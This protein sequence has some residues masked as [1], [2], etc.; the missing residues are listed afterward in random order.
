MARKATVV[1]FV[2]V[3]LIGNIS[4]PR[5]DDARP[6]DPKTRPDLS[7]AKSAAL[8]WIKACS[9]GDASLAHQILVDDQKQR[10]FIAGSLEFGAAL[11]ALETAAVKI[12]GKAGREVTGYPDLSAKAVEAKLKIKDDG[13]RAT[14]TMDDALLP[15]QLRRISDKW[16]VDVSEYVGNARMRRS[17][18]ASRAAAKVAEAVAAEI[19]E[20]KFKTADEAKAAFRERRLAAAEK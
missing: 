14:V 3:A 8:G 6:G 19:L 5:A 20:G 15:L 11:R 10:D 17:A 18:A 1:A 16:R 2:A 4:V 7:T 13:D 12:F 9:I